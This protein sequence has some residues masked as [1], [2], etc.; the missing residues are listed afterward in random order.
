MSGFIILVGLI[1][2]ACTLEAIAEEYFT[3]KKVELG[4]LKPNNRK[5]YEFWKP[6]FVKKEE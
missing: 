1:I 3:L 4:L 2:L 6:E 5:W